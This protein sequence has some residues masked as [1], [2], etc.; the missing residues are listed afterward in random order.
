MIKKGNINDIMGSAKGES[1][2]ILIAIVIAIIFGTML[3][4]WFPDFALNFKILGEVFLNSLMMLVVPLV[5]LSLIV[6]VTR[7]GSMRNL[8]SVGGRT[9]GYY[10]VTTGIA[11]AIGIIIVNIVKP[12]KGVSPGESHPEFVYA[13]G[14]KMGRTVFLENEYWDRSRYSDKFVVI[15]EDQQIKGGIEQVSDSTV[16]VKFWE[17]VDARDQYF[18]IAE[19][20]TRIPFRREGEKLVAYEPQLKQKGIGV[21]INTSIAGK[22]KGREEGNIGETLREI[23]VGNEETQ[24]QGLIP[25]NIFSA[26]A[27]MDILPLIFFALLLGVALSFMG[28]K[29]ANTVQV[30]STLNDAIMKIVHWIMIV[31]PLGIFGL[32]TARIGQAGGF[33]EFLPELVS[34]GKY[35]LCVLIGLFIHGVLVL[36]LVLKFFGRKSPLR[37]AKGVAAALLNAFSTASS[38]ATLPLTIEGVVEQNDVSNK[39]AS[40]V[41]PLGATINMDGTALYEAV[42]AIFIAQVYGIELEPLMMGVVFLTATLAAIGAAGIPEAGLVTMVIVMKAVDLPIEG[43]GLLLSIDWMLDRFRTT[44]N[45]WGDSVGA[46][47]VDRP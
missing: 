4:G 20:G 10:L 13:I 16:Q 45:V 8:S 23:L 35:S 9:V 46:A 12:G 6:G 43:I 40:F 44:V 2:L 24:K 17:S 19:D 36:P 22:L 37:Y 14:G 42:A 38:S 47:V 5:M 11:V 34:L 29:A 30:I 3:G 27:H 18:V 28:D 1:P 33:Q 7:L 32:I 21:S 25:S 39:T 26:M 31:S 41:L 15:L